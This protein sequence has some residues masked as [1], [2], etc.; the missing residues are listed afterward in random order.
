MKK[1]AWLA[2]LFNVIV[3]GTGYLYSG[4]RIFLG[5]AMT[6]FWVLVYAGI[7]MEPAMT[8][9]TDSGPLDLYVGLAYFLLV[10]GFAVDVY[11][12]VKGSQTV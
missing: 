12:E 7:F 2:A 9:T 3:P 6:I 11:A 4:K 8:Q 5:V 1:H 10:A